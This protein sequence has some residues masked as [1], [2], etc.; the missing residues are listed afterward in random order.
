M[1]NVKKIK[2]RLFS[3]HLAYVNEELLLNALRVSNTINK[4]AFILSIIWDSYGMIM[5]NKEDIETLQSL[6]I[7]DYYDDIGEFLQE[8]MREKIK[9]K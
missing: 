8:K 4:K 2:I 7:K 6:V 1:T 3:Q 9:G 5:N